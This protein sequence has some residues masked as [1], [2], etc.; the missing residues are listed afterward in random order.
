MPL[1][2]GELGIPAHVLIY[3]FSPFTRCKKV[4][5]PAKVF[6]PQITFF[7]MKVVFPGQLYKLG[8]K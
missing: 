3:I 2:P 4:Y 5:N 1:F 7:P 6:V 8:L